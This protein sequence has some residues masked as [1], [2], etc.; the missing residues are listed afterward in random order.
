MQTL[1]SS[2]SL[3]SLPENQRAALISL[4]ADD[5][6]AVYHLIRSKLLSYGPAVSAW[7]RPQTLSSD[8]TMRRRA[9]EILSHQAREANDD[10]FLEFCRRNGEDLDLEE[11]AGWLARTRYP[12]ANSEAYAALFDTWAGEL[13]ERINPRATALETLTLINR[14]IFEELSFAGN[15]QY[16]YEPE[17]CYLNRLVDKRSG[18]P[19][20][21]CAIYLFLARRLRLP[22]AGIGLPGHFVCRYQSSTTEIYID[23]FRKGVFLTK[24]DCIKYLFQANYGLAE[25]HLSP[26]SPRRILLRMCNNLVN[27]YGHLEMTQEAARV[28]RYVAALS[29]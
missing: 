22:I 20:G 3:A 24:A 16:G 18:N 12:E 10:R 13:R 5:D 21:M 23:C 11:A 26:V 25:G 9:A 14:F 28:Q 15:D 29:R 19:I 8:P 7:L 6:P 4:L 1:E 2:A 27:T 17:C